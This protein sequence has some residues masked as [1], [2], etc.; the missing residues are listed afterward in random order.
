[1]FRRRSVSKP[2][3]YS[4]DPD[5]L[6]Q[7]RKV[8]KEANHKL[9]SENTKLKTK[10]QIL[11]KE[12]DKRDKFMEDTLSANKYSLRPKHSNIIIKT[13]LVNNL[14]RKYRECKDEMKRLQEQL[15][16]H[17]KDKRNT[18]VK[19]LEA[20][21]QVFTEECVRLKAMLTESMK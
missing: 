19:E 2:R 16:K 21:V 20:T 17:Q 8:L 9:K 18:A 11:D 15:E 4:N 6:I 3:A 13:S 14:K 10:V 1:M 7:D 12:I 5:A